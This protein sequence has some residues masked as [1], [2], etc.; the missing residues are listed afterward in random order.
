MVDLA[1]IK[2]DHR[3]PW[4]PSYQRNEKALKVHRVGPVALALLILY[5]LSVDVAVLG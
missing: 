5:E 3:V 2:H 4:Q 1:V